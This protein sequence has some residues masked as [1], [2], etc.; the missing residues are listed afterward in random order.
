MVGGFQLNVVAPGTDATTASPRLAAELLL[1][2]G[3]PA[4]L[5]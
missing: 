4:V 2:G 1:L 3:P 5:T